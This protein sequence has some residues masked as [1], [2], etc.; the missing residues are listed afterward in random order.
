MDVFTAKELAKKYSHTYAQVITKSDKRLAT[1]Y[2][3]DFGFDDENMA[4]VDIQLKY[5]GHPL[6]ENRVWLKDLQILPMPKRKVFDSQGRT[7]V[8]SRLPNRQWRKGLC[9]EN[10]QILDV[11]YNLL[12]SIT[13]KNEFTFN[14]SKTRIWTVP[15]ISDLF[16]PKYN[17]DFYAVI[18]HLLRED[19]KDISKALSEIFWVS[20]YISAELPFLL[21]RY[22]NPLAYYNN[23]SDTF[24]LLDKIYLQEI[25]DF[26]NRFNLTSK[27]EV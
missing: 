23:K 21:Y 20:T 14:S 3:Q 6:V 12:T 26:C 25:T 10:S 11:T 17:R 1:A 18:N 27:I 7:F 2:F 19:T 24:T 15:T 5:E 16:C 22:A 4:H 13:N 8:Y 9:S